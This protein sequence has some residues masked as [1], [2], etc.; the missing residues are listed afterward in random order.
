M[1][2]IVSMLL[3]LVMTV[4]LLVSCGE[5]EIGA[6]R[7]NY[8]YVPPTV[9]DVTLEM[10]IVGDARSDENAVTA[11]S[12]TIKQYTETTFK[13]SLNVHYLS[14]TEYRAE[15]DAVLAEN[16]KFA[17]AY[18]TLTAALSNAK[19]E[20]AVLDDE[21]KAA[22]PEIEGAVAKIGADASSA[23][24]TAIQTTIGKI[25]DA[26]VIAALSGNRKIDILL[27]NSAEMMNDLMAGE[28]LLDLTD[29]YAS[30]KYGMLNTKITS[31]LLDASKYAD[32][33][34]YSVPNNRM[35]GSYD[36]LLMKES[37]G[38]KYNFGA[39][40]M[41]SYTSYEETAE[42]RAA[43][44]AGEGISEEGISDYVR[45]VNGMYADRLGYEAEGYI[46]NTIAYHAPTYEEVYNG[47][48]FAISAEC[49]RPD[50]AME[51]VYAINQDETLRNLLQYGIANVNYTLSDDTATRI[52]S[53]GNSYFMNPYY[54]G[55]IFNT[56]YSAD[57]ADGWNLVIAKYA[58]VQNED[59]E[60]YKKQ[61]P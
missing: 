30:K 50:R 58:K 24:D 21:L 11:V 37:M 14:E 9:E 40:R 59:I 10:Y 49:T 57:D 56:Y 53:Q 27:V 16:E 19:S 60:N 26:D 38:E 43:I 47:S 46:C 32:G 12:R 2:K 23:G 5:E 34:Y 13:T 22:L 35:T 7:K 15:V 8:T 54:T 33:K 29:Y 31:L 52:T 20:D 1:K 41:A 44:I 42:L 28:K 51:I 18:A 4:L 36:Y 55:N 25:V 39:L 45:V 17:A 48:A 3:C 61:N 6:Y